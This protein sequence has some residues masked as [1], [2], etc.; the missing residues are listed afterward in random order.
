MNWINANKVATVFG[1]IGGF[2]LIFQIYNSCFSIDSK[3][4]SD[5]W[6]QRVDEPSSIQNYT[7]REDITKIIPVGYDTYELAETIADSISRQI[8][9][10]PFGLTHRI[11]KS[12]P[13]DFN[14]YSVV[15]SIDSLISELIYPIKANYYIETSI[16]NTGSKTATSMRFEIPTYGFYE[17][18]ENG[19]MISTGKFS[20]SIPMQDLRVGNEAVIRVWSYNHIS[21]Y[22]VKDSK[23]VRFTF[24]EGIIF[25]KTKEVVISEGILYWIFS[26]PWFSL[27]LVAMWLIWL[28]Y[29]DYFKKNK[30]TN[31]NTTNTN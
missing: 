7:F 6:I 30:K 11:R 26:H 28:P 20:N 9:E 4:D 17:L 10:I 29:T 24:D 12:I 23:K 27:Y 25:P 22:D 31:A 1:I 14:R 3:F 18:F 19:S 15:T 8:G 21:N 5:I 16:R 13:T 2:Y